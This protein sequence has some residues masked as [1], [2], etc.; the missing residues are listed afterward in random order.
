MHSLPPWRPDLGISAH[1]A[2]NLG[3]IVGATELTPFTNGTARMEQAQVRCHCT[4]VCYRRAQT[5]KAILGSSSGQMQRLLLSGDQEAQLPGHRSFAS[6]IHRTLHVPRVP[7]N[8]H[9]LLGGF[10]RL[11]SCFEHHLSFPSVLERPGD[12]Q[13]GWTRSLWGRQSPHFS[14]RPLA[15]FAALSP[16]PLVLIRR[17]R[18]ITLS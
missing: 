16:G 2:H 13:R 12:S 6:N 4:E 3:G 9:P 14:P 11:Q 5:A 7:C 8:L 18:L 1:R 10:S 17:D 15:R